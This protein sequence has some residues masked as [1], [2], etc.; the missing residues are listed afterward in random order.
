ML[1]RTVFRA[2]DGHN[3]DLGISM[4]CRLLI[5][6]LLLTPKIAQAELIEFECTHPDA[7]NMAPASL[8]FDTQSQSVSYGSWGWSEVSLW[9]D[10]AILW[11]YYYDRDG[12]FPGTINF[13]YKKATSE[14][15]F[16]TFGQPNF[17][18]AAQRSDFKPLKC[19]HPF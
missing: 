3:T 10:E 17:A 12:S 2:T 11:S 6:A 1:F 9:A 7:T 14:L 5:C 13:I 18:S 4:L 19:I 8:I 16:R 15:S